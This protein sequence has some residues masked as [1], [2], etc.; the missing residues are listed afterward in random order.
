[1]SFNSTRHFTRKNSNVLLNLIPE[2]EKVLRR[3]L[4]KLNSRRILDNLGSESLS[5]IHSLFFEVEVDIMDK[6]FSP[7]DFRQMNGYPHDIPEKEIEK[8]PTFQGN[9]AITAKK[10]IK[11]FQLCIGKWCMGNAHNHTDVKMRRFCLVI[12]RGCF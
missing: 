2:P 1:L 9:N 5:D 3:R 7:I 8:L 4:T 6:L 12:G 11:A 10:H